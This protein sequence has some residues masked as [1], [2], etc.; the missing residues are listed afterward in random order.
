MLEI[1]QIHDNCPFEQ[2]VSNMLDIEQIHAKR[3]L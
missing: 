2:E 3:P 1:E